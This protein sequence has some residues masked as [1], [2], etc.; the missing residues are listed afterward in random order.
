MLFGSGALIG[1]TRRIGV[2][3]LRILITRSIILRL[4]CCS[5]LLRVTGGRGRRSRRVGSSLIRSEMWWLAIGEK[6]TLTVGSQG[7]DPQKGAPSRR[8]RQRVSRDLSRPRS[9]LWSLWGWLCPEQRQGGWGQPSHVVVPRSLVRPGA[10]P[11]PSGGAPPADY[12]PLCLLR[13]QVVPT[14]CA[15]GPKL[16]KRIRRF[17]AAVSTS[18]FGGSSSLLRARSASAWHSER[19]PAGVRHTCQAATTAH[20]TTNPTTRI[21]SPIILFS[22]CRYN[23]RASPVPV[24]RLASTH[25]GRAQSTS[26]LT[27]A[28]GV[29]SVVWLG[30]GRLPIA[31]ATRASRRW[32]SPAGVGSGIAFKTMLRWAGVRGRSA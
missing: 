12:E 15:N 11:P 13:Q 21:S 32:A 5:S 2:L 20:A 26:P 8:K 7:I 24:N 3:C 30:A 23:L 9:S 14:R 17:Y 22:P 4:C 6:N 16:A 27:R 10:P 31:A 29:F 28:W 18:S 1:R 19:A 25:V